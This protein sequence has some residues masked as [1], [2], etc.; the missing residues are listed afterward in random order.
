MI[1]NG[2]HLEKFLSKTLPP[3][4]DALSSFFPDLLQ[5]GPAHDRAGI[6]EICA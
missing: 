2:N 5:L 4:R 3:A 6:V 1:I